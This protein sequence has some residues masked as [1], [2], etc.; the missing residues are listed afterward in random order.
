MRNAGET[1]PERIVAGIKRAEF[2]LKELEAL[3]YLKKY[4]TLRRRYSKD[5]ESDPILGQPAD[6]D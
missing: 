2:V 5:A 3:I 4:R 6:A 1:D